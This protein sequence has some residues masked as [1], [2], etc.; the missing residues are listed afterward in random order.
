MANTGR[1]CKPP[2]DFTLGGP[3]TFARVGMDKWA[4]G[5]AGRFSWI[6]DLPLFLCRLLR[7]GAA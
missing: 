5:G 2:E 3:A 7:R 1:D 4:V 6:C